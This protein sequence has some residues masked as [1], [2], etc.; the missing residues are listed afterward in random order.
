MVSVRQSHP[1]RTRDRGFVD[2]M[3]LDISSDEFASSK[4]R[5]PRLRLTQ[6]RLD[7]SQPP[8][9][10]FDSESE[11]QRAK[12]RGRPPKEA[13]KSRGPRE[14]RESRRAV[15]TVNYIDQLKYSSES[16]DAD[17]FRPT[18][19]GKRKRDARP[20]RRSERSGR[21]LGAMR[22]RFEDDIPDA[23]GR[24]RGAPK[25]TGA[26]ESFVQLPRSD[27]FR[28]R[29]LFECDT[30]NEVG[31]S[32]EKGV[33]VFCQGCTLAYHVSC[34]GHRKGRAHLVTKVET[35]DF[36][37]QCRRCI[38]FASKNEPTAPHQG[39]CQSCHQ[40]GVACSPFQARKTAKQEQDEREANNNEDPAV[41]MPDRLINNPSNVLFRCTACFQA[42]HFEHLPPRKENLFEIDDDAQKAE[43]RWTEYCEDWTCNDCRNAKAAVGGLIAWRP[44]KPDTYIYG[45]GVE[46]MV[47]DDKEYLIK[48][49]N[50]SYNQS[51]WMP[52]PWVWGVTHKSMRIAF[53]RRDDGRCP[54]KMRTED[55]I[56]EDYLRV[57][58]V[59][60]VEYNNIV[61]DRIEEVDLAR[62]TE[63]EKAQVKFKGLGYEDTVWERPPDPVQDP[64]RWADFKSA[65]ED[66]VRGHYLKPTPASTLSNHLRKVKALNFQE[67]VVL[68]EQPKSLSGGE[69]MD[70][71]LEGLN[72]LYYQWH[73]GH[74]AILADEMG[75]GKTIQVIGFMATLVE[76][77]NHWPFLV[78]VP[79]A[80]CANWRREIKQWAPTLRVV[81]YFGSAKARDLAEK[82]ELFPSDNKKEL[83]CHIVVTSYDAAQDQSC[84]RI[85]KR[86]NW[87]AMIVDEGQRLKSDKNIL[88]SALSML[89][90]PFKLLLTGTPL[91]NN[92][93]ELFNLLQF[94]NPSINAEALEKKYENLT[95]EAVTE[96][97]D[98]LRPFFL[99][100]TKAQ[101]LKFLPTMAQ[102][103]VPVSMSPLQKQ[104]YKS[105]L[106]KNAD[107]LR[108]IFG[109]ERRYTAKGGLRNILMQLR[110]CLC[111]P[112]VYSIAIE[113]R[114]A[115]AAISHRRLVEASSKLQLLEIMLPKL[116]ERGHRVLIFSQFLDMLTLVE[117]FLQGLAME[118]IR[119]DGTMGSLEKQKCIDKFNAPDSS[120]F[121]FLLSTRAGGV[122]INLA[123]ADTV[124]IL[125][126]DFNPHQDIQAISRAHRIG[127]KKKVLIFQMMTRGSAEEKIMQI[128]K[129]KMALDHVLIEAME[130]DDADGNELEDVLR[131]GA[132]ALFKDDGST[133]IHYDS[134]SVDKLLDRSQVEDTK[135]GKDDSAE[136]QFSF[137]RIWQNNTGSMQD[138]LGASEEETVPNST[139][140]DAILEERARQHEREAK[141]KESTLGRGKRNRKVRQHMRKF[142][143]REQSH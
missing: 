73:R 31:E 76:K 124:I 9:T 78:V 51:E 33:L 93:R 27:D 11:D 15:S 10:E 94:L 122:G 101:V 64:E 2:P 98:M 57:D 14:P 62:V 25:I 110:K 130:G 128:G 43:K 6:P 58:I 56:P 30:C 86:I 135:T 70:Y 137:A 88:Y 37:L 34:L 5:T 117:D 39:R 7:Y 12:K 138:N 61:Q 103:I 20:I 127:Q 38:E 45:I 75:L 97:H 126:P 26:K 23:M 85:L 50:K 83:R 81:T 74:N 47:E 139:V 44:K 41:S 108:A 92:Q 96:L 120:I 140:W 52:G 21:A 106:G 115:E 99:R 119:L 68:K 100:R 91:Q 111:H 112:F 134:T 90:T 42:F 60:Q 63:V 84:Q 54:P 80:T 17:R 102:V 95:K 109:G 48:W 22:E 136:S 105:I 116:Q 36:V 28:N 49:H 77:F 53:A 82:Y 79:N 8:S 87:A 142:Q 55:A 18:Q 107:L 66:W 35:G 16:S 113:E 46:D 40:T 125:D 104:L 24:S 121:A 143:S 69:L 118:H 123:T 65:Y 13:T 3:E 131:F 1:T 29:H 71:Q 67:Q 133:D 59:F 89:R 132:E 129:K 141:L 4:S 19:L 32:R 72:W 114:T